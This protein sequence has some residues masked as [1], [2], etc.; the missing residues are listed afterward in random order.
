MN[1]NQL[2]ISSEHLIEHNNWNHCLTHSAEL[3]FGG[4]EIFG[5]AI[6]EGNLMLDT[7]QADIRNL[8]KK[9]NIEIT[10]HPWLEWQSKTHQEQK[11]AMLI[12]AFFI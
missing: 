11:D 8:S 9:C 2:F 10:F 5:N 6:I 1:K 7:Q 4:I 3:G 12:R